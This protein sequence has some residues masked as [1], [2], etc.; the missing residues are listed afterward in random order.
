MLGHS[1]ALSGLA[2][3]AATLPWAP[4]QGTVAQVAWV[5]AAGGFAMLPDLDHS[6]STVS[7]M[8]G[9]ATDVP[10]GAVG[11]L[12]GGHRWG[13]HDALLAPVA[14]GALA[15]AAANL[16]WSSL[17]V[18][19]LA[20]GLALRA[21]HF[22][23][24]G[25]AENTVVG[26]LVLSWGGAWLLLA[27]TPQ[28]TWLPWAV[29]LGVLTHVAGDLVTKQGVPVPLLWLLRRRR[30]ALTPMRTGTTLEKAVLAPLFLGV[31]LWFVYANT[32]ARD[33]LDPYLQA[34]RD[35]G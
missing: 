24:P 3:G 34:L 21:L 18:M 29:A 10:S 5:A 27:H 28:P 7:D 20:I 16:F 9:P 8:W 2:A 14:F 32:G 12:A 25:R 15:L 4:V 35:L 31:A 11:R 22:V 19:A 23:I 26:N 1:H 30:L 17:L 6:G 33:V 13:T